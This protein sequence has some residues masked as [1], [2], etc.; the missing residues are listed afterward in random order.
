MSTSERIAWLLAVFLC[1]ILPLA[2]GYWGL[3]LAGTGGLAVLAW[4][5][6][7]DKLL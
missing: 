2:L 3:A 1:V 7:R 5:L 4:R 6:R